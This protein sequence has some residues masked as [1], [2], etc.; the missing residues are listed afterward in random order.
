MLKHD[1]SSYRAL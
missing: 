1:E